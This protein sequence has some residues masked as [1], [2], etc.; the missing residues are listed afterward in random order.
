MSKRLI[1]KEE[2]KLKSRAGAR[3]KVGFKRVK[4]ILK[5]ALFIVM[6]VLI[7]Q[8]SN[9]ATN[10]IQ[11][12]SFDEMKIVVFTFITTFVLYIYLKSCEEI[13]QTL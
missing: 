11:Q 12:M 7:N 10:I 1:E 9:R 8:I 3:V 13:K 2:V 5:I 6:I 4:E